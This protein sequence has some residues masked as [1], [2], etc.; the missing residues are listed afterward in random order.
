MCE[1]ISKIIDQNYKFEIT[2]EVTRIVNEI[3]EKKFPPK[4]TKSVNYYEITLTTVDDEPQKIIEKMHKILTSK[5]LPK[6]DRWEACLELTAQGKPHLHILAETEGRILPSRIKKIYK[7]RFTCT[8][9]R[10]LEAFRK[11]IK[12][13]EQNEAVIN[14]CLNKKC[15]QFYSSEKC[16]EEQNPQNEIIV[17]N[18]VI[19]N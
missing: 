18:E 10:N 5:M 16:Q 2:E 12:K 6:I 11:Y 1:D 4:E 17:E 7:E 8:K 15:D 14:Y 3:L 13:E 9:V 19:Q